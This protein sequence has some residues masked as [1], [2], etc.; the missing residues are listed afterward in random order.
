[1]NVDAMSE[2]QT[3]TVAAPVQQGRRAR[4]IINPVAFQGD[5]CAEVLRAAEHALNEQGYAF[6]IVPTTE[7]D[8]GQ[9]IARQ[10]V[11]DGIDLVVAAGGDG[12]VHEV[13]AGLIGSQV[14]LALLP[15][16]TMNNLAHSL[17]IP[18]DPLE[19]AQM[20]GKGEPRAIDV[21]IVNGRPFMEAVSIG[22]EA[23]L[24]PLGESM[25]HRGLL[26]AL[27]GIIGGLRL[28]YKSQTESVTIELDGQ[29][30]RVH[31]RQITISN[32]PFYGLNFPT[33]PG[34]SITDGLLDVVTERYNR[35]RE[36][37][38]HYWSIATGQREMHTHMRVRRARRIQVYAEMPLPVAVDGEAAGTTPVRIS[39]SPGA[40]TVLTPST[41]LVAPTQPE[42]VLAHVWRSLLPHGNRADL[43]HL[44]TIDTIVGRW[45]IAAIAAWAGTAVGG[46]AALVARARGWWPF[47]VS[48]PQ[49]AATPAAHPQ[50]DLL[51]WRGALASLGAIFV[52]LRLPLEAAA[53]LL[54]PGAGLLARLLAP[55]RH[56]N[57]DLP[58]PDP[59][60][61][62]AVAA[63]GV[64]A[65]G[66][67]T[68]R[69]SGWRRN[70]FLAGLA[71]L[72]A[73][74]ST[75]NPKPNITQ[76]RQR[77][78]VVL[79]VGIGAAW[80]SLVITGLAF[81]QHWLA[82][83]VRRPSHL[84]R[85]TPA[86]AA[87]TSA[88]PPINTDYSQAIV[89]V[90]EQRMLE[91]GDI[92][93]FGPDGSFVAHLIEV[94]TQSHYHHVALYDGE[95]MVIEAMPHGVRR[96]LIGQRNVT[97]IR[98]KVSPPQRLAVAEWARE[99]VGKPYDVS[100]LAL[101]AFD[102]LFPGL[103]LGSNSANR[104]SCAVF[105]ADAY[106]HAGVDLLP[107]ARWQDL[108]PGDFT[109]LI[110]TPPR[111]EGKKT[112]LRTSG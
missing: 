80:L 85:H 76:A 6:E 59:R 78:A 49:K 103:R 11:Q 84:E 101:I 26:G 1:M 21:G 45:R 38:L 91:R 48:G 73:W 93:L 23:P 92:V 29:R 12:T 71:G 31:L 66:L 70:L 60:A 34:A 110:N 24:F 36:L 65:A 62:Q 67:W 75:S 111:L 64:L 9:G 82:R 97:A 98:P 40:L 44:H 87:V 79:G 2:V 104:F 8:H 108:V 16:G 107:G 32:A 109:Q 74:F 61:M 28:L 37:F 30:R 20:L 95:G 7:H 53:T 14:K 51:A 19:A 3:E 68:S 58:E 22:M 90:V 86:G 39:V 25:R 89:P 106:M 5:D 83:L 18:E 41:V 52:R 15:L 35:R 63:T 88:P 33:A 10:A 27:Q 57:P 69:R 99:Q 17:G 100:G 81:G 56:H 46:A 72:A 77:D 105:V 94:T 112:Q 55:W 47:R 42:P 102:R 50:R 4:L 43:R 96:Y 54:A 13:A